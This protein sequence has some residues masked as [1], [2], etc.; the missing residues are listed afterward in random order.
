ML[1]K[2]SEEVKEKINE[3]YNKGF[4]V[5]EIV[6]QTGISYFSVYGLTRIKQRINPETKKNFESLTEYREYLFKQKGFESRVRYKEYIAKKRSKRKENKALS[7]LIIKRLDE[8]DKNQSWLAKKLEITK[9]MVSSYTSGYL[10]PKKSL[11]KKLFIVLN[12]PYQTLE[13]LMDNLND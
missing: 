2:L 6:R 7:E 8:L 3:L 1:K 5:P 11:Q 4:S 9:G 13:N 12:L 10:I